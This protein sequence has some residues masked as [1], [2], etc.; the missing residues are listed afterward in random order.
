MDLK[1]LDTIIRLISQDKTQKA[2]DEL[3]HLVEENNYN[4][5][6]CNVLLS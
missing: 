1:E 6:D 5:A 2:I 4:I 3:W